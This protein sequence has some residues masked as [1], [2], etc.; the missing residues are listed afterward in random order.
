MAKSV[1]TELSTLRMAV[2]S[3]IKTGPSSGWMQVQAEAFDDV[4]PDF[5]DVENDPITKWAAKE[6]G[7]HV[8]LSAMPKFTAPLSLDL[9]R[10]IAPSMFR[11]IAVQPGGTGV[12]FHR[13]TAVVDGGGSAD[14]FTVASGGALAAGRI[15][16]TRGF[17]NAANNGVFV[18]VA[19][20]DAD[21][22]NVATDTLVAETG[23]TVPP[24][25]GN[26]TLDVI[27][28]QGGAGDIELDAA[29]NLISTTLD[30]TT[31]GIV[32]GMRLWIGGNASEP[33]HRFATLHATK[34]QHAIVAAT[35]TANEIQLTRRS[36]AI[37]ADDGDAKTIW[38]GFGQYFVNRAGDDATFYTT[39]TL[40]GEIEDVKSATSN[41]VSTFFYLQGCALGNLEITAPLK[42]RIMAKLNLTALNITDPVLTADRIAGPSTAYAPLAT[43]FFDTSTDL[44]EVKISDSSGNL[45][46]EVNSWSATFDHAVEPRNIQGEFEGVDHTYGQFT[47]S[48]KMEAYS[49]DY[50]QVKAVRAN[51]DLNWSA[52]VGNHQGGFALDMPYTA[53]RA[54]KKTYE[55]QKPQMLNGDV[56][57]FKDPTTNV[58]M[59]MT[60]F[61]WAPDKG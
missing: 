20:S 7:D 52:V 1:L 43:A 21:S 46:A 14:S 27:G 24:L 59:S 25:P 3:A 54:Q 6:K 57:G 53:I 33:T 9:L 48:V 2:E 39:P 35:P 17:A 36:F 28:V 42:Q 11:S 38:L 60:L 10:L 37:G 55:R 5:E 19:G 45:V 41:T 15:I 40:H 44:D 8:G 22:I 50:D 56:P 4:L 61:A 13:P 16:R 12:S 47:P 31:L 18:V 34:R 51:R 23:I 32:K 30:F 58:V 26:Q 29:G 49:S